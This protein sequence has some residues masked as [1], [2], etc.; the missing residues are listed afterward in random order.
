MPVSKKLL[1]NAFAKFYV[2]R[3]LSSRR[4]RSRRTLVRGGC[5]FFP[6]TNFLANRSPV[7]G[8]VRANPGELRSP[9][10]SGERSAYS[11]ERSPE[12]GGVS[13]L[14]NRWRIRAEFARVRSSSPEF[15]AN[16]SSP[17]ILPIFGYDPFFTISLGPLTCTIT[18]NL[19]TGHSNGQRV[20]KITDADL[21]YLIPPK[22]QH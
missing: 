8:G 22:L 19:K 18:K 12:F 7:R 20:Y 14:A 17:G 3:E 21:V 4:T 10:N 6:R 5:N 1:A 11:G 9:P 13:V 15:A 16:D 2:R